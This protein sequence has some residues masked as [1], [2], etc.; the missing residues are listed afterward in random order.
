MSL[1][2][3]GVAIIKD[4]VSFRKEGNIIKRLNINL[5]YVWDMCNTDLGESRSHN[6]VGK[7]GQETKRYQI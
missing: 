7:K 3:M 2:G 5:N 4:R 6:K 1:K